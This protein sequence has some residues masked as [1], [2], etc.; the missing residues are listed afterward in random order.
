MSSIEEMHQNTVKQLIELYK[1]SPIEAEKL[2]HKYGTLIPCVFLVNGPTTIAGLFTMI[3]RI[4]NRELPSQ[5]NLSNELRDALWN[6]I[7]TLHS[8]DATT[9]ERAGAFF[10]AEEIL[11]PSD[12]V[13]LEDEEAWK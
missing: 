6:M 3:E 5:M 4:N 1:L 8:E 12:P 11:F 2:A 13:D 7:K 10:T 9:D